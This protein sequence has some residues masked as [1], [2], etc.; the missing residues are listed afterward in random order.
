[1]IQIASTSLRIFFFGVI[2]LFLFASGSKEYT[3]RPILEKE[4]YQFEVSGKKTQCP[5]G[6][7]TF[8]K[9]TQEDKLGKFVKGLELNFES[10]RY[11]DKRIKTFAVSQKSG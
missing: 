2:P 3:D 6:T 1:M 4:T 9:I 8:Q 7:A 11:S 5:Q 10:N